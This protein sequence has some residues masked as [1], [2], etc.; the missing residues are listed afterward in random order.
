MTLDGCSRI[1]FLWGK[2]ET[3]DARAVAV[4]Q[5]VDYVGKFAGWR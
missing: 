2:R 4:D 1:D 5:S 3:G